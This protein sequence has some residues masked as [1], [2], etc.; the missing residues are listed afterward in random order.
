M[1][2]IWAAALG[3]PRVGI[4]DDFF[5]LGGDSL[6]GV[7][8]FAEIE[9]VFGKHLPLATLLQGANIERLALLLQQSTPN[10]LRTDLVAIQ[11]NGFQPPLLFFPSLGGETAY[12]HRIARHLRAD[13]PVFGVQPSDPVGERQPFAPLTEIASRYT[14]DLC[15]LYPEGSFRLAGYSFA[16]FLAYETA[17]QLVARGRQVKLVAILDTGPS[18]NRKRTL[19][20]DFGNALAILRNLPAWIIDNVLRS[21]PRGIFHTLY[22][23]FRTLGKA[24]PAHRTS[25]A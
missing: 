15:V 21:Q 13:Q 1:A 10:P 25:D 7:R 18:Q 2:A 11:P 16:G 12:A 22:W 6:L 3:V 20:T 23:Y 19:A 8:V 5:A 17:C 9:K 24:K 4:E 14:E